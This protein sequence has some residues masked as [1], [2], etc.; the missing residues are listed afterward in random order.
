MDFSA[1][2]LRSLNAAMEGGE[3]DRGVAVGVAIGFGFLLITL[4]AG[5]SG[6][7]FVSPLSAL[8]VLGGT[9]GATLMNF[10][11]GDMRRAWAALQEM[12][13]IRS[14]HPVERIRYMVWLA[15]SVRRE[16][17]LALEREADSAEDTF[18]KNALHLAVDAQEG[19]D[20]RRILETEMR[21]S[22]DRATRAV[23]VYETAGTYAPALGLIGT[24]VGLIQMLSSLED[25]ST[26]GPA[27]AIALVSTFYGAVLANMLFLPIAG[28]LRNRCEEDAVVRSITLEG[29]LSLAKQES[30]I[31]VE[32][33]LQSYLPAAAAA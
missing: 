6:V 27:M 21:T 17:L 3:M 18:L 7:R 32:Q 15:H 31:V 19:A 24:L 16:G 5:G 10:S 1:K 30:P 33:R 2:S 8:L 26:V 23:Q 28:K 13:Y 14:Y 11:F 4:V 29:T 25:P 9:F 12:L 20:V 22:Y